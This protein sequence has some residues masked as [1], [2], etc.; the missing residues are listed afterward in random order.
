MIRKMIKRIKKRNFVYIRDCILYQL[1]QL[2][3]IR[4]NSLRYE[5]IEILKSGFGY[6]I[7]KE[8]LTKKKEAEFQDIIADLIKKKLIVSEGETK[9]PGKLYEMSEKGRKY[10]KRKGRKVL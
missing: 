2:E 10:I 8:T 4:E 5:Y 1:F 9:D 3:E 7:N 6:K